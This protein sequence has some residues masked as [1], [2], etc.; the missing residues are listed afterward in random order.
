LDGKAVIP[1]E[2]MVKKVK[3]ACLARDEC[4]AGEFII[5]ARTDARSVE[6]LDSTIERSIAYINAGADM[7]F[8]EGLTSVEEF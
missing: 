2:D 8:P 3:I 1:T 5:C 7:I 4:S 6:G